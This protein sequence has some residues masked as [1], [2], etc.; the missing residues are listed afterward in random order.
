MIYTGYT[1]TDAYFEFTG[2][3]GKLIM[4]A[5]DVILVDDESGMLAIKNTAS[6][7]T[8]GLLKQGSTPPTPP[9]FQGKWKATY[10][11]GSVTSAECD[12]S[13]ATTNNEI[14]KEDLIS[15]ELGECVTS[16]GNYTFSGC[17][18]LTSVT[19]PDTLTYIGEQAFMYTPIT[20]TYIPEGVTEIRSS[21]YE[22]CTRLTSV[23]IPSTVTTIGSS[24]FE[25]CSNLVSVTC[26][27]TTP[28]SLI[29]YL[30]VGTPIADGTGYIYVP[31]ESVD[32]YKAASGWSKYKEQILPIE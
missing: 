14:E 10:S 15:V 11:G 1:K 9:A 23:T 4:P 8:V 26:L 31:A 25:Y 7:C 16:I 32:L 19:I 27:P 24:C 21:A 29:Y 12:A 28:P 18:S 20:E 17:T 5:S 30:F 3:E 13:S 6:R 2:S 22:Y